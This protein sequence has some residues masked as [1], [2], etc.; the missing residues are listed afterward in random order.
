M[1]GVFTAQALMDTCMAMHLKE[2]LTNTMS[3]G[4][5]TLRQ[6]WAECPGTAPCSSPLCSAR[7]PVTDSQQHSEAT[8]S[9]HMPRMG[10]WGPAHLQGR[11]HA[12]QGCAPQAALGPVLVLAIDPLTAAGEVYQA[13]HQQHHAPRHNSD[14]G[15]QHG[16]GVRLELSLH[17]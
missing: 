9:V 3:T 16:L 10:M 11:E 6:V 15:P 12:D 4:K 14:G 2:S 13:H 7:A 5:V 1:V 17:S 8:H